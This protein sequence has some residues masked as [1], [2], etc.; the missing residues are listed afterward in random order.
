MVEKVIK[1]SIVK[2]SDMGERGVKKP[3]KAIPLEK[4]VISFMEGP[5]VFVFHKLA[6]PFSIQFRRIKTC[7]GLVCIKQGCIHRGDQCDR[8]RT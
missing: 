6:S 1:H 7:V 5:Y 2:S 3:G 4:L 8:G